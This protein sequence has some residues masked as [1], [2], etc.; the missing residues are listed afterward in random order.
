MEPPDLRGPPLVR[1][2]RRVP[3]PDAIAALRASVNAYTQVRSSSRARLAGGSRHRFERPVQA[4]APAV[5]DCGGLSRSDLVIAVWGCQRGGIAIE[6]ATIEGE[7]HAL[8]PAVGAELQLRRERAVAI[9]PTC[10]ASRRRT[11]AHPKRRDSPRPSWSGNGLRDL[12]DS[13][14][15]G[16]RPSPAQDGLRDALILL[17]ERTHESPALSLPGSRRSGARCR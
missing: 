13:S 8:P 1:G 4:A 5:R 14:R 9:A 6:V 3:A 7:R 12:L 17:L 16:G 11:R 15:P 10:G 2:A